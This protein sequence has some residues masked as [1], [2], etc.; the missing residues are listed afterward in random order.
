VT[1]RAPFPWFG[2]KRRAAE[3]VW[4]AFGPEVPNYVEP[5]AGSLAVL[6]AR[7]S[8]PRIETVN[9]LDCYLANFWRAVQADPEG[10]ARRAD[11]PVNEA[12]LHARH[13]WLVDQAAFRERMK[14]DPEYFDAKVAGWW[15]W[16]VCQ[17]IGSGWCASPEWWAKAQEGE[18]LGRGR[19]PALKGN[20]GI[21]ARGNNQ[22]LANAHNWKRFNAGRRPRGI[23]TAEHAQRPDL[24][25]SRGVLGAD[26]PRK[27]PLLSSQGAGCGV[28]SRRERDLTG[29]AGWGKRPQLGKGGRGVHNHDANST[30]QQVPSIGGSRGASGSGVH[31][32]AKSTAA[33]VAWMQALQDRLRRVRVCCGDW[34]RVLGRSPT[35]CIG[36]TGVFLDPPYGAA[37]DRDP[38]LYSHDD[39]AVA[40]KARTWAVAHG[41]NRK[42]RIALC[43]YEGE[44]EMPES[45]QCVSWK[46][47]G[48]Y[49]ASAGNTEN[50]AR[51]RIWFSPACHRVEPAQGSLFAESGT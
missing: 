19:R 7:P 42:L 39:L 43:G 44:H 29:S 22:S 50:A 6:L 14:R 15:V 24:T 13:R 37:A 27:R 20:Q 1:L 17:W 3:L 16:G 2:G 32:S 45:W 5:F 30:W 4:R 46:A 8:E 26:L 35:E 12:D 38:R 40:E 10:V 36:V 23:H 18:D 49:A 41:G 28:H 25:F 33:I 11:W 51:E 31:A 21:N 47:V 34:T 9:D 48:G